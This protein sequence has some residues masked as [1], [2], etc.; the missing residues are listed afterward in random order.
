ML[1]VGG[2][3]ITSGIFRM[4]FWGSEQIPR[5]ILQSKGEM[6]LFKMSDIVFCFLMKS[7]KINVRW[8]ILWSNLHNVT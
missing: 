4:T 3:P 7:G 1:W 5:A 6:R 8:A 2:V